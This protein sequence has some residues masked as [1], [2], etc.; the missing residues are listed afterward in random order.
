MIEVR[1]AL[2]AKVALQVGIWP[3]T[4]HVLLGDHEISPNSPR[5]HYTS[6]VLLTEPD[7]TEAAYVVT[8]DRAALDGRWPEPEWIGVAR[9]LKSLND[10][11]QE[12]RLR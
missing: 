12:L 2:M 10:R 5:G 3:N 7:G 4:Q 9:H 8:V 1:R 11:R 6:H